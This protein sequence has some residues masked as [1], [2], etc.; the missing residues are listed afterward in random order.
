MCETI[1][2]RKNHE[3]PEA[4]EIMKDK[5]VGIYLRTGT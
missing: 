5:W 4:I 1:K 3:D 2:S